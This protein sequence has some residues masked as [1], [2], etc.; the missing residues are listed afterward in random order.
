MRPTF[1]IWAFAII[2]DAEDRVLLC[3]RHDYDIWNLPGGGL[4]SGESPWEG[5]VREVKEETGL[6]AEVTRLVGVYSKPDK[7]EIVFL[8]TC[9][10][11]WGEIT[12]ND[13]AKD[14]QYFA[15]DA[16]PK[17]TPPKQ[18]ERIDDYFSGQTETVLKIQGGKSTIEL[19]KEGKL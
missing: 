15:H 5:V 18:V 14:I 6:E 19:I 12:L 7:D 1:T 11:I 9:K 8:F 2:T 4:E 13:E 16:L 17:N 3:L 10:V